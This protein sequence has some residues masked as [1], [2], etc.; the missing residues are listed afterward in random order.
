VFR[1]N[2]RGINS[3]PQVD[4]EDRRSR[5]AVHKTVSKVGP[6]VAQRPIVIIMS[7]NVAFLV[8]YILEEAGHPT[9]AARE[10]LSG[11]VLADKHR[12]SL[13]VLDTDVVN[14]GQLMEQAVDLLVATAAPLLVLTSGDERWGVRVGT[15]GAIRIVRKPLPTPDFWPRSM[16]MWR[17]L[18]VYNRRDSPI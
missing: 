1:N 12:A 15:S 11:S 6:E 17:R 13:I 5:H 2:A 14:G 4:G 7:E 18:S 16:R 9:I 8:A 3:R 10:V